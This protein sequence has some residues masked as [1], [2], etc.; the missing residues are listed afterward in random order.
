MRITLYKMIM[1][2]LSRFIHNVPSQWRGNKH[3]RCEMVGLRLRF[4][5]VEETVETCGFFFELLDPLVEHR[6]C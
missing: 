6:E 3:D 5:K 2:G 4:V 1:E